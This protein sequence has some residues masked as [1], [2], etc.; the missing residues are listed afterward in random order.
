MHADPRSR[1]C[2]PRRGDGLWRPC[3]PRH[4]TDQP[5]KKKH[6]SQVTNADQP[7]VIS[8]VKDAL[9]GSDLLTRPA[10]LAGQPGSVSHESLVTKVMSGAPMPPNDQTRSTDLHV[11]GE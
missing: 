10:D 1:R 3:G 6:P 8:G 5:P 9:S 7:T 11:G 2:H 4:M